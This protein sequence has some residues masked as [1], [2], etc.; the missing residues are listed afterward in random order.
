MRKPLRGWSHTLFSKHLGGNLETFQ[1]LFFFYSVNAKD[2]DPLFI[3][4][5]SRQ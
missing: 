4:S 2:A 1:D 5:A 3:L